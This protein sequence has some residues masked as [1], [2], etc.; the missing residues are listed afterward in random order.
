MRKLIFIFLIVAFAENAW[1]LESEKDSTK[2]SFIKNFNISTVWFEVGHFFPI[3]EKHLL[4]LPYGMDKYLYNTK[5]ETSYGFLSLGLYYK[6]KYGIEVLYRHVGFNVEGDDYRNY[7]V[8]QHPDYYVPKTLPI[9]FYSFDKFEYRICYRHYFKHFFLEP[10]FQFGINDYTNYDDAFSIK[11]KGSNQFIQYTITKENLRKNNFSYHFILNVSK[12]FNPFKNV[13]KIET[14]L[15]LEFMMAPTYYSYTI[16]EKPYGQPAVINN[17]NVKQ[18][19][20]A[21]GIEGC[22]YFFFK[23]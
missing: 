16:E 4:D 13:L 19:H 5:G 21:I 9:G 20:P 14:A 23:K 18:L 2:K 22:V 8:E 12:R 15:K 11:E 3:H 17:L 7:I 6:E 10:K 1:A